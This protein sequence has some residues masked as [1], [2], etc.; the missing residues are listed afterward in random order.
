MVRYT[1]LRLLVF[2]G[3][4]AALWLVGL[5]D[6]DELLLLV[7][8]AGLL[9]AVISIF[10]L[11]RFREDYAAQLQSKIEGRAAAKRE[12]HG[13]DATDEDAEDSEVTKDDGT[14]R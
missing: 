3:C 7:V 9:S 2:A 13:V 4:L 8:G 12:R 1:V 10:A 6:R 11:R 5:R 14:F